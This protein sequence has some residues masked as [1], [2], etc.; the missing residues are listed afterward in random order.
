MEQK[1][2]DKLEEM[3]IVGISGK[4]V[5][6]SSDEVNDI[7]NA[8]VDHYKLNKLIHH[9]DCT[10][11]LFA[12]DSD[13]KKLMEKF[14]NS[15]SDAHGLPIEDFEQLNKDWIKFCNNENII[16]SPFFQIEYTD[17]PEAQ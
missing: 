7:H 10:V 14:N 11:G 8:I 4:S 9:K 1:L 15:Q 5:K 3:L 6:P 2:F 12:F 13:P 16:E 17:D